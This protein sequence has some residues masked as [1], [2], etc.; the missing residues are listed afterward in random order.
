MQACVRWFSHMLEPQICMFMTII[1]LQLSYRS[2]PELCCSMHFD[3]CTENCSVLT[4]VKIL[5]TRKPISLFE[6]KASIGH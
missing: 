4:D 3:M 5:A 2:I 6:D 1:C